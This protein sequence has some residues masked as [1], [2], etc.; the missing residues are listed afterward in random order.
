MLNLPNIS[1][2]CIH[3]VSLGSVL[4]TEE[5][6]A[7][8]VQPDIDDNSQDSTDNLLAV[9]NISTITSTSAYTLTVYQKRKRQNKK[10]TKRP[11]CVN[12]N[13]TISSL[14]SP[15]SNST[16]TS[17]EPSNHR[18]SFPSPPKTTSPC[19]QI[20]YINHPKLS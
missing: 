11:T 15:R 13:F 19:L 2:Q 1:F 3:R 5:C 18:F 6:I 7:H 17:R 4:L 10:K 9:V 20:P 16:Y 14:P 8:R 12:P